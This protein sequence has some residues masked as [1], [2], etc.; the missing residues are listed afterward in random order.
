M[1]ELNKNISKTRKKE[2]K[3]RKGK[4]REG[5]ER[6]GK[7]RKGKERKF[8]WQTSALNPNEQR[9]QTYLDTCIM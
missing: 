5:K 6:K 4:E 9:F 3:E 2:R 7:E 8:S 1:T